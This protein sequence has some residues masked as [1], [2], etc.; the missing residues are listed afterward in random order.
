[1]NEPESARSMLENAASNPKVATAVA[2]GT[3][4]IGAAAKLDVIQGWL[5]VVTMG[6]GIVT[7]LLICGIQL[8]RFEQA[9]RARKVAR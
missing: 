2:A 6:V 3:A 7:A 4:S 5:S 8:I 1:M 9:W